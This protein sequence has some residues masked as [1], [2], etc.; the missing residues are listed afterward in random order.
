MKR[1]EKYFLN[2][3]VEWSAKHIIDGEKGAEYYV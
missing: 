2:S 3:T 1:N